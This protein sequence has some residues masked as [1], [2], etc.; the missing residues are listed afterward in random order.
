MTIEHLGGYIQTVRLPVYNAR[1][2]R[3]LEFDPIAPPSQ[4]RYYKHDS[5]TNWCYKRVPGCFST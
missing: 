4:I 1:E 2:S 3:G 5:R